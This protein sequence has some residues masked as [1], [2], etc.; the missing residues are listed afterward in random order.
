M[1]AVRACSRSIFIFDEVDKMPSGVFE[2]IASL[3]DHH[4]HIDGVDFRKSIFI[5]L[6]NAG[7]TEIGNALDGI[8][9]KGRYREQT[10]IQDF[11][12]I[13][14]AAAYNVKGG[15]KSASMI[16]S[17]LIDH[18]MPFLPL[19]KRHVERCVYA[20]FRRLNKIPTDEQIR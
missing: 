11:E 1:N 20:E 13:A 6:S 18:F 4:S 15:L 10:N 9:S 5:F 19:E 7:G 8:M 2:S 14:E 17:S 3:L 12:Q 16:T